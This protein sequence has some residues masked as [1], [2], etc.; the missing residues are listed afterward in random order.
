[1]RL[2][3][4]GAFYLW[5]VL[6]DDLSPKIS[7][8]T[9]LDPILVVGR[10]TEALA[11]GLSIV[12]GL[13][14][15]EDLRL[16]FAFRWTKLGNRE[17]SSWAN[18]MVHVTGGHT[19]HDDVVESFVELALDTPIPAIAPYVEQATRDL[20]LAFDGYTLPPNATEY[21]VEAVLKRQW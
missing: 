9:V 5:R 3:P 6:P 21:W 16:G 11:V 17:L 10:V 1:M 4:K 13:G 12:K 8:G 15:A 20:F 18:P 2:D 14:W 19:A 7:P